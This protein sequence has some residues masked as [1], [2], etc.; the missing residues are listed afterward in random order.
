MR[1]PLFISLVAA[2]LLC[3]PA[4]AQS[5]TPLKPLPPLKLSDLDT[6]VKACV[7]F[8]HYANGGWLASNPV[9]PAFSSWGSFT[10][11]TERNY[12]VLREVLESAARA[13]KTTSN[14]DTKKLGTF[15]ASCMD[16]TG[17]DAAGPKPLEP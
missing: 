11:L 17:A 4:V 15:Y 6:S 3:G 2:V 10:E 16:S 8:Y 7:D 1:K 13:A 5:P 14:P 12:V 9:P